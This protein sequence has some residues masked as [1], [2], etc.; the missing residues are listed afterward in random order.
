MALAG[1]LGLATTAGLIFSAGIG[2]VLRDVLSLRS[3]LLVIIACHGLE[4]VCAA[5]AWRM[6]LPGQ[7]GATPAIFVRARW[8][9]E[10]INALLPIPHIG[11]AVI[12]ARILTQHN[13]AL[14]FAA[15][16]VILD[17]L[18]EGFSLLAFILLGLG[19]FIFLRGATEFLL[20]FEIAMVVTG[21]AVPV[22]VLAQRVGLFRLIERLLLALARRFGSASLEAAAGF[23]EALC[24]L[25]GAGTLARSGVV[26]LVAWIAGA[27]EVWLA[28]R[29]M[30]Y[31]LGLSDALVLESLA[32]A[33]RTAGFA[34]P[35]GL[36][37]QEGGYLVIGA[38]L[39]LPAEVALALSL[40]R[41]ISQ[42]ALGAPA[43]IV[44]QMKEARQLL[45]PIHGIDAAVPP[46]P[47]ALNA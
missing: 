29:F 34:V 41:R 9:R 30:G 21:L 6:L 25:S 47:T 33:V 4:V 14:R 7:L 26:H 32:M 35:A 18:L 16:S 11:D 17:K 13:L 43:L 5:F 19:L 40:V 38:L 22:A 42:I 31:P 44:W 23:D 28:L 39:G 27:G 3:G 12:G 15:A 24:T 37:V 10:A 1:L 46:P 20:W 8:I 45:V 36:G 2:N